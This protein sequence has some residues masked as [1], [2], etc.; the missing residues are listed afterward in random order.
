MA[1]YR[2][3]ARFDE[4][5]YI[6][7]IN[8][9]NA[10]DRDLY[11]IRWIK[12]WKECDFN[13]TLVE[14]ILATDRMLVDSI[15]DMKKDVCELVRSRKKS[16]RD[17]GREINE[18]IEASLY[19]DKVQAPATLGVLYRNRF[20][21]TRTDLSLI[22][23]RKELDQLYSMRF[24]RNS[25]VVCRCENNICKSTRMSNIERNCVID[26][27]GMHFTLLEK[28]E[29]V[30]KYVDFLRKSEVLYDHYIGDYDNPLKQRINSKMRS[31]MQLTNKKIGKQWERFFM[32]LDKFK[33]TPLSVALLSMIERQKLTPDDVCAIRSFGYT[34]NIVHSNDV[35]VPQ[36]YI[37]TDRHVG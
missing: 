11:K 7:A 17:E 29:I 25:A 5:E 28:N 20:E 8:D 19:V 4:S 37:S 22:K 36:H 14:N 32:H 34:I 6:D 31:S 9:F 13:D 1:A 27:G 35:V 10:D 15:F 23:S 18:Q 21:Q 24:Q 16:A 26:N 33:E 30:K 3:Y 12:A 2:K